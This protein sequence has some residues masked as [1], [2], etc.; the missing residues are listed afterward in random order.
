MNVLGR[1]STVIECS[2]AE[3][4]RHGRSRQSRNL[5]DEARLSNELENLQRL[6]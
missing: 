3:R 4:I 2:A 5:V 6:A 1:S